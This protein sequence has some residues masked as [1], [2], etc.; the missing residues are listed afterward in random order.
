MEILSDVTFNIQLKKITFCNY[1]LKIDQK[2]MA[3]TFPQILQLRN[4]VN[5][6]TSEEN[7]EDII[8]NENYV[9]L[10][11][12]DKKHLLFLEIPKLLDLKEELSYCF[13]NF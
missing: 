2:V 5:L 9:L 13:S 1:Q 12:A 7:L 3:L 8:Q 11:I 4:K 6:L 10:F